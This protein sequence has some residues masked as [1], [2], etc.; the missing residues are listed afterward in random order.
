MGCTHC[1]VQIE[2]SRCTSATHISVG[3]TAKLGSW[4]TAM[5]STPAEQQAAPNLP[6]MQELSLLTA[7]GIHK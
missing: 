1:H 2:A 5:V 7:P 3:Q 6:T 4:E